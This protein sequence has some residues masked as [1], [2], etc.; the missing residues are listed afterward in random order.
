LFNN[1]QNK[2]ILKGEIIENKNIR[3]RK[4]KI[5]PYSLLQNRLSQKICK[6][7][8]IAGKINFNH[9]L[10]LAEMA[11]IFNLPSHLNVYWKEKKLNNGV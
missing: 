8:M 4:I 2:A 1:D 3:Y 6:S 11:F 10:V 7:D 9:K 5:T